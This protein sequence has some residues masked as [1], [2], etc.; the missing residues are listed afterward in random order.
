MSVRQRLFG[1]C[2]RF[3][4]DPEVSILVLAMTSSAVI[5]RLPPLPSLRDLINMYQLKARKVLSQNYIMD[6]NMNRKVGECADFDKESIQPT[7]R[8]LDCESL[9]HASQLL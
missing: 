1:M 4:V 2:A 8:Y 6:M 9:W 5:H 7:D 3:R